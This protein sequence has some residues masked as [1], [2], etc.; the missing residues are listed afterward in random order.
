M[1]PSLS[2][3]DHDSIGALVKSLESAWNAGDGDAFAA[4]FASD[5]D[6]VNVRAEHHRGRAEIAA[7]HKGIFRSIYAGSVNQYTPST[8]RLLSPDTALVH[9]RAT[10]DVPSGPPAGK[11]NAVFSMILMRTQSAG[12]WEIASFHNTMLPPMQ[13]K[14]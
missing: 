13:G 2:S 14:P 3:R 6:F 7:G 12:G 10:L 5:A 8:L 11:I 4:P 9:V 1:E